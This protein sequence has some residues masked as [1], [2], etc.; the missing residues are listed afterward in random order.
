MSLSAHCAWKL[1]DDCPAPL[2]PRKRVQSWAEAADATSRMR[3]KKYFMRRWKGIGQRRVLPRPRL[4]Q[5]R[6]LF[7]MFGRRGA[8]VLGHD[9][10][11]RDQ[12][13]AAL[14]SCY[15]RDGGADLI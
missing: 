5:L 9:L 13:L 7:H 11:A 10:L 8:C 3:G 6:I 4:H 2:G 14:S 1:A 12:H 15:A